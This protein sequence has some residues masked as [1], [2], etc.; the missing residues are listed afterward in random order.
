MGI[1]LPEGMFSPREARILETL[2]A[3]EDVAIAAIYEQHIG[4]E[5]TDPRKRQNHVGAITSQMN[6]KLRALGF[7]IVPGSIKRTY[8]LTQPEA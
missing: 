7:K 3:G 8:R 6:A 1:E 2:L 4:G 5:E